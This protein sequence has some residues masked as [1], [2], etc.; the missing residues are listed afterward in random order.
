MKKATYCLVI[1]LALSGCKSLQPSANLNNFSSY[2]AAPMHD[3]ATSI[4]QIKVT[5]FGTSTLL[6]DDGKSQIMVDGFFSRLPLVRASSHRCSKP[7]HSGL[8][9]MKVGHN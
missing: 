6:F 9:A 3:S 7:L 5:F 2:F 4:G 8:L 1:C